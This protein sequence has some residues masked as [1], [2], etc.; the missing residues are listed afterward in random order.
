MQLLASHPLHQGLSAGDVVK[1]VARGTVL[2]NTG[3]P[4]NLTFQVL[5]NTAGAL[6]A[7]AQS[8]SASANRRQWACEIEVYVTDT[9]AQVV[10]ATLHISPPSASA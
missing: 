3:S 1:V 8:V 2:N 7:N 6:T 10:A 4:A 9:G 5:M